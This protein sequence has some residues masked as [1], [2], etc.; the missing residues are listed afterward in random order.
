MGRLKFGLFF[1]V[2][3]GLICF[4]EGNPLLDHQDGPPKCSIPIDCTQN[5]AVEQTI[6]TREKDCLAECKN[7]ADCNWYTYYAIPNFPID[8]C[9]LL[10]HC[11]N[12]VEKPE[13]SSG[14]RACP[15]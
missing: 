15:V 14:E 4:G 12:F 11:D 9:F 3:F 10:K 7:K 8:F 5:P 13:A 2:G 1:A 6:V